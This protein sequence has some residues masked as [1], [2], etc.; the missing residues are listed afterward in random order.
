MDKNNK[1][2]KSVQGS[3]IQLKQELAGH[4]TD[5]SFL[6]GFEI[7]PNPDYVLRKAGKTSEVYNSILSDAHVTGE[8]QAM[9]SSLRRFDYRI[10]SGDIDDAKANAAADLCNEWVQKKPNEHSSWRDMFWQ[11]ASASLF[12][13][14]VHEL[15]Y[16]SD[17]G[18]ILPTIKDR[19]NSRFKWHKNGGLRLLTK[20]S[21]WDGV[22]VDMRYFIVSTHNSSCENPYGQALL[23]SCF[24]PYTFKNGGWRF[25]VKFCER[26]G[27]PWPVG[28]YP[29]GA[30]DKEQIALLEAMMRMTEDGAAA[31]PE[32]SAIELLTAQASGKLSQQA[33]IELCNREISKALTAQA[34][35]AEIH[36]VGARSASEIG[37]ERELGVNDSHR[38]IAADAMNTILRYITDINF[39]EEVVAPKFEFYKEE[40]AGKERA[41][42][43]EIA[44]RLTNN[45]SR[46][47]MLKELNI[48]EA[49]GDEDML[50]VRDAAT[51]DFSQAQFSHV[52]NFKSQDA[53]EEHAQ[54]AIDAA[55][56]VIGTEFID[57]IK[58]MLEQHDSEGKTL[59]EFKSSLEKLLPELSVDELSSVLTQA[60]QLSMAEGL[61]NDDG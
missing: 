42:V 36:D 39:G 56:E 18:F 43:Y 47:A 46:S 60:M 55:D 61:S 6:N 40:V 44:S 49:A 4:L 52:M 14:R 29:L 24:W 35:T 53:M 9:R 19:S 15:V 30:S 20:S 13:M 33:L 12:G 5:P 16:A 21:G 7:L 37:R 28:R 3:A 45:V 54:I 2:A 57:T 27:L 50:T 48:P 51:P 58:L 38:D 22:E 1:T 10:T 26:H 23:S 32:G 41:E 11:F 59:S 17:N 31:I 8:V 25:F 34:M